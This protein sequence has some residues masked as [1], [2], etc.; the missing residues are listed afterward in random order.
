MELRHLRYFV[1]VAE[2]EHITRAAERLGMQQPPLSQ[3]IRALERELDVQLFRRKAR[4]VELTGAGRVFLENARAT[5]AQY[6]RTLESTQRAARGEQGRLCIGVLPT[7]PFHPFVPSVI[8]TFRANFPLVSLTLDECL[9]VE[10]IEG[11][12]SE[13]MDIAFLR[14]HLSG[15]QDLV[16]NPLL[17]EPMVVAL[18]KGHALARR[19]GEALP[20]KDLADE[21]FIVYARQLGPAFY[22]MT[23]AACLQAGFSPHLGQEAPRI[24]SALSLVAAGLGISIVPAS[25]QRMAMDGIVYRGLKGTPQLKAALSLAS[26]RGDPSVVV[27]NFLNLVKQAARTFRAGQGKA[28]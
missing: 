25:M 28:T 21:T 16:A 5:L 26:R 14:S 3:R 4:G 1:V 15:S 7:A 12:R 18:P 8:R 17:E 10:A 9:R 24:T 11:L 19:R 2:E 22:E 6:D 20:L 27:R 13:R 23:M